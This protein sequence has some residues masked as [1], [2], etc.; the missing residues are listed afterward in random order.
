MGMKFA[1]KSTAEAQNPANPYPQKSK[2]PVIP[3][4]YGKFTVD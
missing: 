4:G 1:R 3:V 2:N